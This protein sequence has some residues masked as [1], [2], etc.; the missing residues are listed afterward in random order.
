MEY[1][2]LV[3]VDYGNG[4]GT[5]ICYAPRRAVDV[6]DTVLTNFGEGTVT[7]T[8]FTYSEDEVY[9]FFKRNM[10]IRQVLSK[11]VKIEYEEAETVG[12]PETE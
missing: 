3:L 8:L 1:I 7:E 11:I 9:S 6:G 2:D 12:V 4:C 5:E 10:K